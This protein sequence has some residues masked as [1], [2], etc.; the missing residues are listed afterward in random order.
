MLRNSPSDRRGR[1]E[2]GLWLHCSEASLAHQRGTALL[3]HESENQER[4][5][6]EV[7]IKPDWNGNGQHVTKTASNPGVVPQ[8]IL[9]SNEIEATGS[10]MR[11]VE[12]ILPTSTA[13]FS[14][15]LIMTPAHYASQSAS[16]NMPTCC[17]AVRRKLTPQ[18]VSQ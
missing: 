17:A 4:S 18:H 1:Q 2:P 7:A 5:A 15:R 6:T 13:A 9:Q 12:D 3:V 14:A 11:A 16:D 8:A 10:R